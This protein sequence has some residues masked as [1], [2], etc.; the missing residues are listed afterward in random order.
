M[1]SNKNDYYHWLCE[2]INI[3]MYDRSY[4]LLIKKLHKKEFYWSVP[5]DDNRG[6]D[7]KGL[8][9]DFLRESGLT[10]RISSQH[11]VKTSTDMDYE[12][13]SMLEML[14][15]LAK[16][17]SFMLEE[18]YDVDQTCNCFWEMLRNCGL[19]KF[20]DEDYEEFGGDRTIDYILDNILE[21]RYKRN[22]K[23]GLFPLKYTKKDQ[24]KVEIW[25]QMCEY[26]VE[27][28]CFDDVKM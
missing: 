27:N 10:N 9:G 25:Y 17:L 11:R 15:A 23:G 18:P 28:Y 13:C 7:G 6:M 1:R 8:R 14:I 3:N 19:E 24:R 26:I 20:T 22:G 12:E 4:F 2:I 5:N 21:R 16:R